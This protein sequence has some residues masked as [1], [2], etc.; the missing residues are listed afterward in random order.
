M[1]EVEVTTEINEKTEDR[2]SHAKCENAHLTIPPRG[3]ACVKRWLRWN[4]NERKQ[5]GTWNSD[6]TTQN[7]FKVKVKRSVMQY[8]YIDR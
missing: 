7:V 8:M 1:D 5:R 6:T 3:T 2:E 4:S